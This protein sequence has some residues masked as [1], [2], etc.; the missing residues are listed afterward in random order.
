MFEDYAYA[1]N[2]RFPQMQISGGNFPPGQLR[3]T[4]ANFVGITKMAILALIIFGGQI[5]LFGK[6]QIAPPPIYVWASQNKVCCLLILIE[7]SN[8]LSFRPL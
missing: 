4:V 1:I 2:Q 6:L 5:D 7:F 3:Q 8:I